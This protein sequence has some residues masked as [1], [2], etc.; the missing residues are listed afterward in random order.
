[1]ISYESIAYGGWPHCARLSNG[2]V[3]LV[4]TADVGPRIIR[5][6]FVGAENPF[7][8]HPDHLGQTGG[9]DWRLYGGHR[10]WHAPEEKPRTYYPDNAPVS[11][12]QA[13]DSLV[14]TAPTETT[15][16]IQ[17][18]LHITLAQ[19]AAQA[20]IVHRLTNRHVWPVTLAP[21]ALTVMAA[22]GVAVLPVPPRGSHTEHLLPTHSLT[23]WAYTDMTDPR[24]TWGR[25]YILL[26][27]DTSAGPQKVG[28]YASAG[29]LAYARA[30]TLFV[31][32]YTPPQP[33][34]VYP[35][36]NCTVE[37]FTNQLMLEVETTG[38]LV[39]LAPGQSVEHEE[40]WHLFRDVP[41]PQSE[42]DVVTHILPHL[43]G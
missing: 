24:W 35:D 7:F 39:T 21:W 30:G 25:E 23:L 1:M 40:T 10:L 2:R 32:R 42:A 37:T 8:E 38:P 6:G 16:G 20:H 19:E 29:W 11:L 9:S 13:G 17:K 43:H 27:Q 34:A 4:I 15:T 28:M 26:R 22:G 12:A 41:V 31:K 18:T 14:V 5:F 36:M 33:G 3:D